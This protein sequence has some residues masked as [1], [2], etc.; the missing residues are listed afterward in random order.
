VARAVLFA[1]AGFGLCRLRDRGFD[2]LVVRC[3]APATL[4]RRRSLHRPRLHRRPPLARVAVAPIIGAPDAIAKQI[5]QEF[6]SAVEKQRVSVV[7][8]RRARRLHAARLYRRGQRQ[9]G[10]QG[11]HIWT[12]TDPTGNG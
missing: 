12:F 9:V 10:D 11:V 4:P 8:G 6:T 5:Q 7:S 2:V 1:I 3:L